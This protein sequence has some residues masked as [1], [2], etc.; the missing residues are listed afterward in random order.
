MDMKKNN[1]QNT[2]SGTIYDFKILNHLKVYLSPPFDFDEQLDVPYGIAIDKGM[3][4]PEWGQYLECYG[5]GRCLGLS[6]NWACECYDGFY[7]DC[8]QRVC[9]KGNAW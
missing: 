9:P 4:N 6:G 5:N 7:G 3:Q 8:S 2:S 1:L